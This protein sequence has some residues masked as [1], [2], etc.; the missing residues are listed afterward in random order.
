MTA[1]VPG[2]ALTMM[3]ILRGRIEGGDEVVGASARDERAVRAVR[4]EGA[5]V[6]ACVRL[7]HGDGVPVTG[8]V[9]GK[10]AAHDGQAD[11]TD[12]RCG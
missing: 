2:P 7:K 6:R 11:D 8:E 9:A 1:S 4:L 12:V 3:M 5:S 10:V